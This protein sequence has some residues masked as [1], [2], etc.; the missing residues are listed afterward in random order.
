MCNRSVADSESEIVLEVGETLTL[1][2]LDDQDGGATQLTWYKDEIA[3][4]V[5]TIM[6]DV[7][8]LMISN[9]SDHDACL[10][11]RISISYVQESDGGIYTCSGSNTDVAELNVKVYPAM[12]PHCS[13]KLTSEG[14]YEDTVRRIL[15]GE[16]TRGLGIEGLDDAIAGDDDDGGEVGELEAT[17]EVEVGLV[18]APLLSDIFKIDNSNL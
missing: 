3:L 11:K 8:R 1:T 9:S 7:D 14:A 10:E 17:G 2:C 12:N 6:D 18:S 4:D 13:W 5:D 16:L 15:R